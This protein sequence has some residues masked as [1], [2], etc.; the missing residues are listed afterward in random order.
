MSRSSPI[1]AKVSAGA[2]F[3]SLLRRLLL[4][5]SVTFTHIFKE[6]N[7]N[8]LVQAFIRTDVLR[9]GSAK[10]NGVINERTVRKSTRAGSIPRAPT[11]DKLK[12]SPTAASLF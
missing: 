9:A 7:T 12:S 2:L 4:Q 8:F 10:T 1:M 11:S 6:K 5:L 3:D